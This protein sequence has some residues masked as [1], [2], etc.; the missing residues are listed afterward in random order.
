[1]TATQP[2]VDIFCRVVDNLGDIGV[3]WRLARQLAGEG[4]L[5]VRLFVDDLESFARIAPSLNVL[6]AQQDID[7]VTVV[8]WLAPFPTCDVADLV[9]EAFACEPPREYVAA[10]A[11]RTTK[12]VW[13]NL[14]YLSAEPWVGSHHLLP[15]PHPTL[16]LT[17]YFYFPGFD[18]GTGGLI[19]EAGLPRVSNAVSRAARDGG[20]SI[21]LFAY[22]NAP[23]EAWLD[24]LQ[25]AG[26]PTRVT[27][28]GGA[29]SEKV[30]HWRGIQATKRVKGAPVLEFAFA[31]FVPQAEFDALLRGH[32]IL[33][34]RGEDSFVRAQWAAKP[35]VWQIYP[36]ADAAHLTKLDAFLDQYCAGLDAASAQAMRR[37]WHAWN[38]GAGAGD[39]ANQ[40]PAQN[41]D[42]RAAIGP[43][44]EAFHAALPALQAHAVKWAQHLEKLPDLAANLLS[45]YRK[46]AKI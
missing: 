37:L 21:L 6:A 43:A 24:A 18:A 42:R 34:V 2:R 3:T 14:E 41:A 10:M 9:I 8:K 16:P 44:W 7:G 26:R 19:R 46:I 32:D 15:S 4:R 40:A 20:D 31:P 39:E 13:L 29:F 5:P 12:P 22:P 36:Q 30:E 1:L 38:E 28:A 45:F 33:F 27:L 17:K 25:R 11:G 23:V 35:F